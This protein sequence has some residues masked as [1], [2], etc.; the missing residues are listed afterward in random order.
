VQQ[1]ALKCRIHGEDGD[2]VSPRNGG[3]ILHFNALKCR[4]HGEDGDSVSPRN[5]GGILHFNAACDPGRFYYFLSLRR[6]Q[7]MYLNTMFCLHL[8]CLLHVIMPGCE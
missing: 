4:I 5:G 6:L 8:D 1:A 2:R 3:A 7:D